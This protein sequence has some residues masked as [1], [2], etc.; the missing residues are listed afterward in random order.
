MA[1]VQARHPKYPA[2]ISAGTLAER[3]QFIERSLTKTAAGT[4]RSAPDVDPV[5]LLKLK[6][7]DALSNAGAV[8]DYFLSVLFP[9]EGTANLQQYRAAAI[10]Y[11]N[12]GA[13]GVTPSAFSALQTT[14]TEYDNRVRGMVA[15]LMNTQR[16]QEQ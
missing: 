8:A 10:Q 2:W 5:A 15:F 4:V 3:L 6:K 14:T 13:N 7:P 12:T 11:L 9:A 1:S 16:F